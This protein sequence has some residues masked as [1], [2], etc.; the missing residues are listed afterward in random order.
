FQISNF[1]NSLTNLIVLAN[2]RK[3][4]W[5]RVEPQTE[6]LLEE[7]KKAVP[8]Q[9]V[10]A[11]KDIQPKEIFVVDIT[12]DE[13]IL[14]EAMKS[15]TRY[16]IRLAEKRGVRVFA[17]QAKQYQQQFLEF[18]QMTA[19]RKGIR[20]HPREYYETFF[21]SVPE[22]MWQLFVAQYEQEVLVINLVV[23]Y[24][25]TAIY[26]HGGSNDVHRDMMAPYLLQWEQMK[27]AQTQGCTRYDFGGVHTIPN[28]QYQIPNTISWSGI[29][30]FKTGFSPQTTLIA[31]PGTY[32]IVLNPRIYKV[33]TFLYRLKAHFNRIKN[34]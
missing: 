23:L 8:Y 27:F 16:N 28:T 18:I 11:P 15:K 3:A 33:Y 34:F 17:T 31:F 4:Q 20:A 1:K 24:G 21:S 14:F 29:T 10:K 30:R 12:P 32:D 19:K 13:S 26:L 6:G 5:V 7:V 25:T 2:E 22:T 9:V